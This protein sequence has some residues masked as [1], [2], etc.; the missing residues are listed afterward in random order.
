MLAQ[1][2]PKLIL[3]HPTVCSS[4]PAFGIETIQCL[5]D[6]FK[7]LNIIDH[8]WGQVNKVHEQWTY[9]LYLCKWLCEG[10]KLLAWP[11]DANHKASS[12]FNPVPIVEDISVIY[13][14]SSLQLL[15][16]AIHSYSKEYINLVSPFMKKERIW[17]GL[18]V[19]K[20]ELHVVVVQEDLREIQQS[21]GGRGGWIAWFLLH[22]D[23]WIQKPWEP[24]TWSGKAPPLQRW[25][26]WCPTLPQVPS[27]VSHRPEMELWYIL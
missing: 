5:T 27:V 7:N 2:I 11:G 6:V 13:S 19:V 4:L 8:W 1:S 23:Y 20:Y 25:K 9:F 21:G 22:L 24:G 16:Y 26:D 15:S 3:V 14:R 17:L 12:C 10:S 18:I